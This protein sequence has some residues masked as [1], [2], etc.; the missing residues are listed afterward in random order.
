[1]FAF[2]S[3]ATLRSVSAFA[4][5]VADRPSPARAVLIRRARVL[6]LLSLVWMTVEAV[7]AIAAA[8][9]AGSV[10]LLGFGLDSLIELASAGTVLWLYSGRRAGV[11]EAELRAQRIVAVCFAAL[12]LY[13]AFDSIGTLAGT[14]RPETSLIGVLVCLGAVVF[15]PALARAKGRVAAELRSAATAGDAAQSWLCALAAVGVLLSIIA[16]AAF[17][18]WWLDPTVGLGIAGLAV[19]EGS[20]AWRGEVC[21]DCA[22]IDWDATLP[23][24]H[25]H[26]REPAV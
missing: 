25:E 20:E 11:H 3:A 7:A 22:R 23:R 24:E 2:G 5:L 4:P 17:G 10:A 18:W 8:V 6:S 12:A 13:L 21:A 26:C 15:M 14:S 16:N 19:R 1:M 9:I